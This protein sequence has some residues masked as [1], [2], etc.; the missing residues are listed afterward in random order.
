[1]PPFDYST[2]K[3]IGVNL[4]G[5]FVLEP[6]ITPSIFINTNN[7]DIVDEFTM[8]QKLDKD[9]AVSILTQH[10]QTWITEGARLHTNH[11]NALS[12]TTALSDDFVTMSKAGLT[13]VR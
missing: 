10:W 8:G 7:T 9:V 4:G 5:W 6:W 11:M 12:L 2:K 3:V 13:H 1:M